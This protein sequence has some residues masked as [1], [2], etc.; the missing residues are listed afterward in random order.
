MKAICHIDATN[1]SQSLVK[2]ICYPESFCFTSQQ[3]TWG[4]KHEKSAQDL[5]LKTQKPKHTNLAVQVS[6]L[7]INPLWPFIGASPDG[8]LS[9]TCCGGGTLEIKCPFC[10]RGEDVAVAAS[11][12]RKFCLQPSSDGSLRLDRSHAYY[13]QVQTQLF[14]SDVEYCDFCVCTFSGD[15]TGVHIERISKDIDLWNDCVIKAQTFFKTCILPELLG[16]W[17]TR[18]S[19]AVQRDPQGSSVATAETSD[20]DSNGHQLV[21]NKYCYCGGPEEGTMIACENEDCAIEWFHT[22]CLMI[23]TI[24]RGKWYCPDCRKLPKFNRKRAC[25]GTK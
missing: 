25:A 13:Y 12:D 10:H 16:K 22:D 18:P 20:S 1:P 11:K 24:P 15:E 2:S 6:G 19:R 21:D 5:Y 17:Y 9:C 4:C 3:T 8:L 7:V 14:V 23:D